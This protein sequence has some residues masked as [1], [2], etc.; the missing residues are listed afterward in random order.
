[1]PIECSPIENNRNSSI[2]GNN[3]LNLSYDRLIIQTNDEEIVLNKSFDKDNNNNDSNKNYNLIENDNNNNNNNKNNIINK[4]SCDYFKICYELDVKINNEKLPSESYSRSISISSI[5]EYDW[6]NYDLFNISEPTVDLN[7]SKYEQK[8]Q[9]MLYK[10]AKLNLK[11][12]K[13]RQPI[14]DLNESIPFIDE[15]SPEVNLNEKD[16]NSSNLLNTSASLCF[17]DPNSY[18][19]SELMKEGMMV[20]PIAHEL[21]QINGEELKDVSN[22]FSCDISSFME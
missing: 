11:H 20:S 22:T 7:K 13:M 2:I 10:D 14:N 19:W 12:Q 8:S 16:Q 5:N 18:F 21:S 6:D 15:E 4:N 3:I 1:L 9:K 17:T